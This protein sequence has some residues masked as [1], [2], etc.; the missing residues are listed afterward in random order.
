MIANKLGNNF[1]N[2]DLEIGFDLKR[3]NISKQRTKFKDLPSIKYLGPE[4]ENMALCLELQQ[5]IEELNMLKQN[6]ELDGRRENVNY[7]EKTYTVCGLLPCHSVVNTA[8]NSRVKYELD[9]VQK[10]L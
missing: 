4:E 6:N 7:Y 5:K 9:W 3:K 8:S 1:L 2:S 10:K